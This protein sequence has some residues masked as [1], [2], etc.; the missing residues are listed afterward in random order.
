MDKSKL[1]CSW[2]YGTKKIY[3]NVTNN[4]IKLLLGANKHSC[5]IPIIHEKLTML[6][7]LFEEKCKHNGENY[8]EEK[9]EGEAGNYKILKNH[10]SEKEA[11]GECGGKH[12]AK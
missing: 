6:K 4:V 5:H 9:G 8:E 1:N 10:K 7:K 11:G 12:A 2:K 3:N